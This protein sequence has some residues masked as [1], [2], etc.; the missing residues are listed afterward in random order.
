VERPKEKALKPKQ[1]V[2]QE[3]FVEII[4]HGDRLA[5]APTSGNTGTTT[6]IP[7]N[8]KAFTKLTHHESRSQSI[9]QGLESSAQLQAEAADQLATTAAILAAH[10]ADR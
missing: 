9:Q 8:T 3:E 4:Q 10:L 1:V 5:M 2:H 6:L 7:S